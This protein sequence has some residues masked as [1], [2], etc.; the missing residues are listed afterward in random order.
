M[1]Q[2]N[3]YLAQ[4]LCIC[5]D[6]YVLD[7]DSR[8]SLCPANAFCP[9]Q[10][11]VRNC[12]NNGL[13]LPGQSTPAGCNACPVG[14]AM[15]SP[16]KSPISCRPCAS[17]SVCPNA[18]VELQCP[19]GTYAPALGTVCA[20]C[21]AN[22]YSAAGAASCTQ[23][24]AQNLAT[25]PANSTSSAACTCLAGYYMDG[26]RSRC[27]ACPAGYACINNLVTACDVGTY[28]GD[29]FGACLPCP[30]GTY[31]DG[32]AASQCTACPG[33]R[34]IQKTQPAIE[35][36]MP[37]IVPRTYET[38]GYNGFYISATPFLREAQG[39]NITSWTFWAG[40]SGCVVT[41]VLLRGT[42]RTPGTA[43]GAIDFSVLLKGTTR[44]STIGGAH[45]FSFIDNAPTIV[46]PEYGFNAL[47][48]TQMSQT[49]FG[50][51]FTG[52]ECFQYDL[53]TGAQT[54][55]I[56]KAG[57][58]NDQV[59]VYSYNGVAPLLSQVWSVRVASAK[60]AVVPATTAVG[61]T[62]IMSCMCPDGYQQLSNGQCQGLCPPGKYIADPGSNVCSV[63]KQGSYCLNS[64][65]YP[66]PV[67]TSSLAGASACSPC[68]SPGDG[69]NIQ[70]YTCGLKSCTKREPVPLGT[71]IAVSPTAQVPLFWMGL[72]NI[73]V[74]T[75]SANGNIPT[76]WANGD[77]IVGMVLNPKSDRPY[78]LV[79]A[80][81]DQGTLGQEFVELAVQFSYMCV[82]V[83]CPDY[84]LLEVSLDLGVTYQQMLNITDFTSSKS[85]W[86]TIASPFFLPTT[87]PGV[88]AKPTRVR[89]SSQM[90]VMS[91][92][93]WLGNI[94][95]VSLG[96][97]YYNDIT[98]MKL[99]TTDTV[100]VQRFPSITDY[101]QPV[102]STNLLLN[103]GIIYVTLS[104]YVATK[105]SPTGINGVAIFPNYTYQVSLYAQGVGNVTIS[106]NDV[107]VRKIA[108]N[109]AGTSAPIR[110]QTTKTPVK[111]QIQTAGAITIKAPS[112]SIRSSI[113]G[114]QTCLPSYWCNRGSISSC[115]ANAISN[116]GASSPSN[117]YCGP[118]Y[119]GAADACS[120][121]PANYYCPG[122]NKSIVCPNGTRT[123][124][125][126]N[127]G[128]YATRLSDCIS[129]SVDDY[130]ALGS[131]SA[132]PG[133]ATSPID[134]WDVTQC[135]C[136]PGYYGIAP[137]CKLCEP[138]SYCFNG[139]KTTCTSNGYSPPGSYNASQCFCSPGYY[140]VS[141]A[142]CQP[143]PESSFCAAG[144]VSQC[145][146]NMWSPAYSS[147]LSN[148]TCDYGSYP[149]QVA[150]ALC[151]AGT[152]KSARGTGACSICGS[153]TYATARGASS[154]AVCASCLPGSFSLGGGQYQCQSCSAGKYASGLASSSCTS[155]WAGSYSTLGS[156]G[157]TT[158]KA[159]TFSA[160]V[161]APSI[162][163]C[164]P[165]ELG[166]WSY[167]NSTACTLCGAC[168]YWKFPPTIYFQI[169]AQ[170]P[171]L[172]NTNK[173]YRFAV[174]GTDGAVFMTMGTSLYTVDLST[175]QLSAPIPVQG[176]SGLRWW[177]ASISASVLGN[178]L[179]VIQNQDVY[180]LDLDMGA[181]SV[182]YPARLATC[183]VEDSTGAT[184]VL[185][186]VQPTMVRQVDPT[187]SIDLV[188]YSISGAHSACV[189]PT[190]PDSVFVTGTFGLKKLSKATGLFTTLKTDSA[191]TVCQIT[192]DGNFIALA[193]STNKNL[194]AY[195]IFDQ[196]S[197]N[198]LSGTVSG[199][200]FS[201]NNLVAGIDTIGVT[202]I[203]VSSKDS[204]SCPP[205]QFGPN[206]G[207][208][209]PESCTVC[210]PGNLC[211]GG[212]NVT[213][214]RPGTFGNQ[215]G[216]REQA[217][218]AVCPAGAY[219]PG[220]VC[221][222][223][224]DCAIV[225]GVCSG[226]DC[227]DGDFT[228]TCPVGTYST[229][230]G[231]TKASDCPLCV[232][233]YY[234]P[235]PLTM[236][237]CP[238][239]TWSSVG[240]SDLSQCLCVAGYQCILT[241]V[242]HAEV[243]ISMSADQFT[244]SVQAQ[245]RAAIAA[246]AGIDIS[247]VSIQGVFTVTSPPS[248]RRLLSHRRGTPWDSK[249]ISIHTLIH[250]T[251][252]VEFNNLDAH[253][254]NQGLPPH[255]SVRVTL[256]DEVVQTYS[257]PW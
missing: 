47:P 144:L 115:Y 106:V 41:P 36:M 134:S 79:Q 77:T 112:L 229:R 51:Y 99:L 209:S 203:S 187:T 24:D 6:G 49:F 128:L 137:D 173:Y 214:C 230:T 240:A 157:C 94:Q 43:T 130:C 208:T 103:S 232:A 205:G 158:C 148:C 40:H 163:A 225:N 56:W 59:S 165:C 174:R 26:S 107:D 178:Y 8:C 143:C 1:C 70:L 212:A 108:I 9:D 20:V 217:Q 10:Y 37:A 244:P 156:A 235:N 197:Y 98:K 252:M 122:G 35:S 123:N 161:A 242:V 155:C 206:A 89:F 215:T 199:L 13:S 256:Q 192:Q 102:P 46:I 5:N 104:D 97:W 154:S 153:G 88:A 253:L 179:Y 136:D 250:Q 184:P 160:V 11:T 126:V 12:S 183:I 14:Y 3:S 44:T 38:A 131:T 60:T 23:C 202:N 145:P 238:N 18:T 171:V 159:G 193:S 74:A 164:Q 109:S 169:G 84:L 57:T 27:I 181:Y 239:N 83:A 92:I 28:S 133:H 16:T 216:L 80:D 201:G 82:G 211:P 176:P 33:G 121:C 142:P 15:N 223:Q 111:F 151:S 32:N 118:G 138:G 220:A 7:A 162:T 236:L 177:F 141:N 127:G 194:V 66:C 210:A 180:R 175:G 204:R 113:I 17:G 96:E 101:Q 182:L 241:K 129:C 149:V 2:S 207:M 58:Y 191:Y 29:R 124:P 110:F 65:I 78:A 45:N 246:A 147:A 254:S 19:A 90:K 228:T 168:P 218:C 86:A 251:H 125:N 222:S 52:L 73:T 53:A 22:T 257:H 233:G 140:G 100:D 247:L 226:Q 114:C 150:C 172:S 68:V 186:I 119:F 4:N 243:V 249:A 39:G 54:Y 95:I 185:W 231:L 190:D 50:W 255:R 146:T 75:G 120:P 85:N 72:G 55:A 87:D 221:P 139:T 69:T 34:L 234:C 25:S 105:S 91:C 198:I 93:L 237:Q 200:L 245:Y 42:Y 116:P 227:E 81:V 71:S 188:T 21:A 167:A 64:N 61:A 170:T 48:N 135:I 196:A 248:G 195:S 67:D 30:Q 62:S 189:S 219:C 132:C 31:M 63:C 117:C 213:A 166:A 224:M 76:P 152:F